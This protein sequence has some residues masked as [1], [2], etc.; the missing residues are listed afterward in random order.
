MDKAKEN[1]ML[2]ESLKETGESTL[3]LLVM[4]SILQDFLKEKGLTDEAKEYLKEK[5]EALKDQKGKEMN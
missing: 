3:Q 2:R 4:L 1:K 5:M